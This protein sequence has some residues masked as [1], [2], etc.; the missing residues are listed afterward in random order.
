M[1]LDYVKERT[2][3]KV[4][5]IADSGFAIYYHYASEKSLYLEDIYVVPDK[6]QTK[7]GV[8]LLNM[9]IEEARKAKVFSILGS[10]DPETNNSDISLKAMLNYGFKPYKISNGLLFLKKEL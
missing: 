6:R 5:K 10:I 9:I 8:T 1:W 4:A 3:K 2:N 7:V